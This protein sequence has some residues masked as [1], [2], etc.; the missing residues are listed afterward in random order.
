VTVGLRAEAKPGRQGVGKTGHKNGGT[1]IEKSGMGEAMVFEGT[2]GKEGLGTSADHTIDMG[3]HGKVI[4]YG[5]T[6]NGEA[7]DSVH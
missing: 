1:N 6:E 5:D 4:L 7:S 2:K 3:A